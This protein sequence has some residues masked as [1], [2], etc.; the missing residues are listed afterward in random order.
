MRRIFLALTISVLAGA[1]VYGAPGTGERYLDP[2]AE[3]MAERIKGTPEWES[4]EPTLYKDPLLGV[5]TTGRPHMFMW[6]DC[7]PGSEPG[8]RR[9]GWW[10]AYNKG[11]ALMIHRMHLGQVTREEFLEFAEGTRAGGHGAG[12]IFDQCSGR[13]WVTKERREYILRRL[14]EM[15]RGNGV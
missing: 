12:A 15:G 9:E 10:R 3:G 6:M 8:I 5:Y 1:S 4:D 2:R 11:E 7:G 14:L 13:A